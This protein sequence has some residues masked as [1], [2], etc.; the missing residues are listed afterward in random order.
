MIKGAGC[1]MCVC[2]DGLMSVAFLGRGGPLSQLAFPEKNDPTFSQK[3][4]RGNGD[5]MKHPKNTFLACQFRMGLPICYCHYIY[6]YIYIYIYIY[7]CISYV[8]SKS[9]HTVV[10]KPKL[11]TE[12]TPLVCVCRKTCL[13]RQKL[14]FDMVSLTFNETVA[15]GA[16]LLDVPESIRPLIDWLERHR[17]IKVQ[18]DDCHPCPCLQWWCCP[19]DSQTTTIL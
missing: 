4:Q 10:C 13:S 6:T 19:A 7:I 3:R 5:N 12:E 2:H 14:T 1:S 9:T 18:L 8:A 15:G 11:S 17:I 16:S